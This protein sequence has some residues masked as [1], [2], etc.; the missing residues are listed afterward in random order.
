M[1]SP[2]TYNPTSTTSVGIV[3]YG[4][5]GQFVHELVR[6]YYPEDSVRVYAHHNETDEL[7]RPL[8]EVAESDIVFLCVPIHT[9]ESVLSE[10]VPLVAPQTVVV[11]VATVK[12]HTVRLLKRYEGLRFVALHP[13][14]GPYSYI[15]KGR[16]LEGLRLVLTEHT[17]ADE[18][19][20]LLKDETG[21]RGLVFLEMSPTEHDQMLAET[22]FLTHYIGQVVAKGGF[23][24]TDID[25][26]SFGFLMDAV[27][28]V[29]NDTQL[30]QD[31]YRFNP[32]CKEVLERFEKA[33]KETA[34]AFGL[35]NPPMQT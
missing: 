9:Y 32:Y 1:P 27:E 25:T 5:F 8:A 15:K 13:M 4:S 14:F 28:S 33:E 22:L 16:S 26:V 29:K 30:F 7:F 11:D 17:L 10:L 23:K 6:H 19:L 20:A 31:V 18:E 12:E 3:G 2:H 35:E 24:R 21:A 34:K